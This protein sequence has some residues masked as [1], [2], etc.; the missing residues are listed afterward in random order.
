MGGVRAFFICRAGCP[1]A[2][3]LCR[4]YKNAPLNPRLRG[5]ASAKIFV[6][7][8]GA[9]GLCSGHPSAKRGQLVSLHS[10]T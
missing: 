7:E 10:S 1:S 3:G 4:R 8:Y 6:E 9:R 2:L 5:G